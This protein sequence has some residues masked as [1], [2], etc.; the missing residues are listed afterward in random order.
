MHLLGIVFL[1]LCF[2]LPLYFFFVLYKFPRAPGPSFSDYLPTG[3]V[4]EAWRDS[5]RIAGT[6]VKLSKKYGDIYQVWLGSTHVIVCSAQADVV[7][8]LSSTDDFNRPMSMITMFNVIVPNSL[9]TIEKHYHRLSRNAFKDRFNF[10]LLDGI[11]RHIIEA[12]DELCDSVHD[13]AS[14]APSE[15]QSNVLEISKVLSSAAFQVIA[16]AA[17]G[18]SLTTQQLLE[19]A[20]TTNNLIEEMLRDVM[21]YPFRHALSMFGTRKKLFHCKEKMQ[22]MCQTLIQQRMEEPPEKRKGRAADLLDAIIDM[23]ELPEIDAC[24]NMIVFSVA[25][26]HTM[27]EL[28]TW[29]LYETCCNK[30]VEKSIETE[31]EQCFAGRPFSESIRPSDVE[32]FSYLT[33]VWKETCR[34]HPPGAFIMR[35]TTKDVVLRGSKLSLPKGTQVVALIHRCHTLEEV[36]TD[37][38]KFVPERWGYGSRNGKG[39]DIASATSHL[40]FGIGPQNCAGKF[41]ADYEALVILAELHRRFK[42]SLGC[43]PGEVRPCSGWVEGARRWCGRKRSIATRIPFRIVN[44]V[45]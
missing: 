1:V 44:R 7:Q 22:H 29:C 19:F 43:E 11:H 31:I 20:S 2:L 3:Q 5:R 26:T 42:F 25:G 13:V 8:I 14:Q 12:I 21:Q 40:A 18:C 39:R 41:L 30:H 23:G 9:F 32:Q 36:W 28:L 24:S 17:F 10:S 35:T 27:A 16:N 15:E 33:K 4:F 37:A 6:L 38:E 45:V 34:L